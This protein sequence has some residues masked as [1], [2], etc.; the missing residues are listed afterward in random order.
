ML[1]QYAG[2]THGNGFRNA[3]LKGMGLER[4]RAM[5]VWHTGSLQTDELLRTIHDLLQSQWAV[6]KTQI[7]NQH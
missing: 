7:I 3:N 6:Y 2:N 5:A 4:A 1:H